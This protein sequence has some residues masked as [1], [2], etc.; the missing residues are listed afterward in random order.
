M[1]AK[2]ATPAKTRITVTILAIG[3]ALV[4]FAAGLTA[5][6]SGQYWMAAAFYAM[7]LALLTIPVLLI[8]RENRPALAWFYAGAA[9]AILTIA[10]GSLLSLGWWAWILGGLVALVAGLRAA[11]LIDPAE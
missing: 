10:L 11:S 1:Y 9:V 7:P 6:L 4:V 8:A 5:I 3:L 2:P